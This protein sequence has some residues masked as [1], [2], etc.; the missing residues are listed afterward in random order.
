MKCKKYIIGFILLVV[1]SVIFFLLY[2]KYHCINTKNP[3]ARLKNN[4]CINCSPSYYNKNTAC[5]PCCNTTSPC[6]A[7]DNS[8]CTKCIKY[9]F[10]LNSDGTC[11]ANKDEQNLKSWI[12]D[13]KSAINGASTTAKKQ[14][15][16]QKIKQNFNIWLHAICKFNKF[17]PGAIGTIA[18]DFA[19]LVSD[20]SSSSSVCKIFEDF[21]KIYTDILKLA[22]CN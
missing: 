1:L 12:Q 3:N 4:K 7:A 15:I 16:E 5:I 6:I 20:M 21:L 19:S 2:T 13:C 18:R 11:D 10:T 22:A 9:L 14:K 17:N 8:K